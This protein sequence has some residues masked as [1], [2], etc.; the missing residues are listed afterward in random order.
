MSYNNILL[1]YIQIKSRKFED[2]LFQ[3]TKHLL[4]KEHLESIEMS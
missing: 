4:K 2:I 1:I 3:I